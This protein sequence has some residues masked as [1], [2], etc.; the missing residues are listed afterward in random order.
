MSKLPLW[1]LDPKT[2]RAILA[3]LAVS[4]PLAFAQSYLPTSGALSISAIN[5]IF[6]RGNNL[7]AYRGTTYYTSTTGPST[8]S[9]GAIS[10][11]SFYGTGPTAN[12]ATISY[13]FS[14]ST[15][16]ASLNVSAIGGYSSG[17][18][19]ITVTI[20]GGVYL[21]ATS[22]GTPGFT[23]SGG[24][25]G[26]TITIVNNGF[27]MGCGGIGGTGIVR[28]GTGGGAG[29][30]ALSL[31]TGVAVTVNNTNGSAY[32]GGGGGGGAGNY[33]P[34][35]GGAGGGEGGTSGLSGAAGGSGGGPG[36][37][38]GNGGV[39]LITCPCGGSPYYNNGGGG[40]GRIFPGTGAT[41]AGG[42]NNGPGGG[43]GGAGSASQGEFNTGGNGGSANSGGQNGKSSAGGGG[44]GGGWGASGGNTT[45][46]PGGPGGAGGKAVALNGRSITWTSGNTTRVY[47]SVS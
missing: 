15:A 3:G 29:G 43:A 21:Y 42:V 18:S 9:S 16:N 19:D 6:S 25:T 45:F 38:G 5:A 24:T 22:T 2:Y 30:T 44:G 46:S 4:S 28:T 31:S 27:I 17:K 47:G 37:S 26:D 7:N 36:S 41:S 34:G 12:R 39:G 32:I 20:N 11:N 1:L 40:G 13:T 23:I 10:M 14:S 8:F 35:G 33:G